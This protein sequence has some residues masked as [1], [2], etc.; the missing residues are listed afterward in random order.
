MAIGKPRRSTPH[1]LG[2]KRSGGWRRGDFLASRGM[3]EPGSPR[4]L[5]RG[6]ASPGEESLTAAIAVQAIEVQPAFGQIKPMRGQVLACAVQHLGDVPAIDRPTQEISRSP[7]RE[8]KPGVQKG[9]PGCYGTDG[10][11]RTD[12]RPLGCSLPKRSTGSIEV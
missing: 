9:G 6:V 1:P 11:P 10:S 12:R 5:S 7:R 8:R 2:P 4:A 3:G